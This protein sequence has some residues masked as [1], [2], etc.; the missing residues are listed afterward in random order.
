MC[1]KL[2]IKEKKKKTREMEAYDI[3]IKE[4]HHYVGID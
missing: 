2:E 3:S 1:L 4:R